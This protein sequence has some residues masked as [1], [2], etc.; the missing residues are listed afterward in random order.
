MYSEFPLPRGVVFRFFE[1]FV[2]RVTRHRIWI[3]IKMFLEFIIFLV[4][5][6]KHLKGYYN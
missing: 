3:T 4:I 1:C 6:S 2:H 5:L